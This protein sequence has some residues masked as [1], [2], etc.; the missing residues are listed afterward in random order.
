MFQKFLECNSLVIIKIKIA[1]RKNIKN[2]WLLISVLKIL[3]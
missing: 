3:K 2:A 1:N